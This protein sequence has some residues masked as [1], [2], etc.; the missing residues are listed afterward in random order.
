VGTWRFVISFRDRIQLCSRCI[1][2]CLDWAGRSAPRAAKGEI[3]IAAAPGPK[4]TPEQLGSLGRHEHL[5][6]AVRAISDLAADPASLAIPAIA[7]LVH[8]EEDAGQNAFLHQ[9][10]SL[11]VFK[12]GRPPALGRPPLQATASGL[13][14]WLAIQL[15]L[16][17]HTVDSPEALASAAAEELAKQPLSILVDEVHRAEGGLLG[18]QDFWTRF[19]NCLSRLRTERRLVHRLYLVAADYTGE[20]LAWTDVAPRCS[21]HQAGDYSKMCL[22][23]PLRQFTKRDVLA[24]LLEMNAPDDGAG[25]LARIA[26]LVLRRP[27][28]SFDPTP[29]RV[30]RRLTEEDLGI[31]DELDG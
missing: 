24:W 26:D 17:A 12:R 5:N 27:N 25:R 28:G 18:F 3:Q 6:A 23:P 14:Q 20:C 22:L 1:T 9:I 8:G 7:L 13:A 4:L 19:Y 2:I 16:G 15:G 10:K 11:K 31:K 29:T 30:F 21:G